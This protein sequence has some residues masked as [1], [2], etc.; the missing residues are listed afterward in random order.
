MGMDILK[1]S[2]VVFLRYAQVHLPIFDQLR[3]WVIQAV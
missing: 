2:S 1:Y 3:L